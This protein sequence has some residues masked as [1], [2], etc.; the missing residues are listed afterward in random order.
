MSR[1]TVY[2]DESG[3][4]GSRGRYFTI[5]GTVID[6]NKQVR[7][8]ELRKIKKVLHDAKLHNSECIS[9]NG[10]LKAAN[11]SIDERA[12]FLQRITN[13]ANFSVNYITV[14]L[15]HAMDRLL[16]EQNI[17]YNYLTSYVIRPIVQDDSELTNLCII[18]DM[19]NS[20]VKRSRNFD[21]YIKTKIWTEWQAW[22]VDVEIMYVESQTSVGIQLADFTSNAINGYFLSKN[23]NL[24]NI[25]RPNIISRQ[26]FP[27]KKFGK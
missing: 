8:K 22:N 25:I 7:Q 11:I 9:S 10:E 19:R 18:L 2:I 12:T 26:N 20:A 27:Y 6:G 17:F 5:A 15:K 16:H 24:V 14:D 4:F 21:D 3:N 1:K 23:D 13:K